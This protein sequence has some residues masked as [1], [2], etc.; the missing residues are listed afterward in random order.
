MATE[1][2]GT[3]GLTVE[4]Q[5]KQFSKRLIER[6]RAGAVYNQFGRPDGIP[7]QGGKSISWR[8]LTAIYP[9]GTAGSDAAA[10]EPSALT[11][12]TY[13]AD[14]HATWREVLASVSQYGQWIK[15]SDMAELQSID[16]IVPQYVE[17][18]SEAMTDAI[19]LLTRDVLVAGTNVQYASIAATRGGASGVGSGMYLTLAEL[20]EA[21]RTLKRNNVRPHSKG[22]GKYIVIA[23]PDAGHDLETQ[24]DIINVWM[25]A[26]PRTDANQI[27]DTEIKDLPGGFRIMET[28]NS[29]IFVDAGLSNADVHATLVLGEGWFGTV[30]LDGMPARIIRKLRNEGGPANPLETF[31]SVGWKAAHVAAII[32][33]ARGVR[34]EHVASSNNMG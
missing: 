29:R 25:N 28:T 31:A 21:K 24:S 16:P 13:P 10:S 6:F 14:I 19:D 4:N 20:R 2:Y 5:L 27:W 32:D 3:G 7:T 17:A 12:G 11:E 33:Q 18:L 30:K 1:L 9:A 8:G 15:Y 22:G 34:I 23:H 26:G